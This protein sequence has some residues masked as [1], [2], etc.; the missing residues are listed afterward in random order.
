MVRADPGRIVFQDALLDLEHL[1]LEGGKVN[2]LDCGGDG[3]ADGAGMGCSDML[4]G[5]DELNVDVAK[6]GGRG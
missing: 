3:T 2:G 5:R 1:A 6:M 4:G